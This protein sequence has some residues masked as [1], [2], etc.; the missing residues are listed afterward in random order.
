MSS[1]T[2]PDLSGKIVLIT[3]GANGIGANMVRSFIAQGSLV[4][5]CDVD[6][7]AGKALAKELGK[8]CR[9]QKLDL[10]HEPSIR[11]WVKAIGK[12]RGQVDVLVNNAARDPRIPLA[13][14]TSKAWDDLFALNLRSMFLLT[15]ECESWMTKAGSG[16][17][18][19]FSSV[20]FHLGPPDMA[21]YVSTKA[22]IQGLTRSTAR[23]LGP[24][25]IR[26][27]TLAP[28]WI[29]TNRQLDEHVTAAAKRQLKKEQC[30]P[31]LMQPQQIADLALFLA[32]QASSS[33][34]G[35][36]LV[37]DH[38]WRYS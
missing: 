22:G 4:E 28:G 9:F 12:R 14:T 35:Q 20:T 10:R 37:A 17:I 26:V 3:G 16:S 6:E 2:Y 25:R 38:G 36:E 21:A 11:K 8:D 32:S 34:T 18:I 31:D 29:M 1:A 13:E 15:R 19:N 27:N 30:I 5:F 23:E 33:L 7:K 24:K